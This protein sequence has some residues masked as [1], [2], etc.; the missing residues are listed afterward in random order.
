MKRLL[1]GK[2]IEFLLLI[3]CKRTTRPDFSE[4]S[5]RNCPQFVR[6]MFLVRRRGAHA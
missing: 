2:L 1:G 4:S 3:M 6:S 5:V